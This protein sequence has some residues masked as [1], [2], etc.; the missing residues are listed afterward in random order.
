MKQLYYNKDVKKRNE[1]Y[2]NTKKNKFAINIYIQKKN[3]GG[4]GHLCKDN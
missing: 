3:I 2:L 1:L 4:E